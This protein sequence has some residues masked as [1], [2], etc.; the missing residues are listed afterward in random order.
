MARPATVADVMRR[1]VVSTPPD[2]SVRELVD[3][4]VRHGISGCVVQEEGRL[5][6]TVSTTDL[7]WLMDRLIPPDPGSP[8]WVSDAREVLDR[9]RVRDI[10]TPDVFGVEADRSL[11]ELSRFFSRTGLH[12]APVLEQGELVGIV[13]VSDMLALLARG[14]AGG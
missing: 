12:R 14:E 11:E 5:L 4:L 3:L 8:E 13:S 1:Q 6:G 7:L 10:M 9:R 2:A